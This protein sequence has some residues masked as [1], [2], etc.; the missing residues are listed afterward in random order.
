[1]AYNYHRDD[2]LRCELPGCH[3]P[4]LHPRSGRRFV[5]ANVEVHQDHTEHR[6][7]VPS[8]P[9]RTYYTVDEDD[10]EVLHERTAAELAEAIAKWE[11]VVAKYGRNEG[12]FFEAGP[13]QVKGEFVTEAGDLA[14]GAWAGNEWLW[15][16]TQ[17]SD[18]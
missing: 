6:F 8:K 12:L 5:R 3:W 2:P 16:E 14:R 4:D 9:T 18:R 11:K 7:L 13:V 15:F 10:F 1:M 17:W